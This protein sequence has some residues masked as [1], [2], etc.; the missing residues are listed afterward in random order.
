MIL[1]LQSLQQKY[2][3]QFN[4]VLHIGANAGGEYGAYKHFGI[5]PI[6]FVEALPHI[7]EQAWQIFRPPNLSQTALWRAL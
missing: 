3:I 6:I 4:G 2:N 7:F 5:T 1:D